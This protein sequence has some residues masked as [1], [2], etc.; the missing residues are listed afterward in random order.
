MHKFKVH[1]VYIWEN[2][3]DC[4]PKLISSGLPPAI[5]GVILRLR[6]FFFW[7]VDI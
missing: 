4:F 7:K 1:V 6:M 5:L 2:S 3:S